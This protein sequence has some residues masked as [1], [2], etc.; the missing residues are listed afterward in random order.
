LFGAP[1]PAPAGGLFGAAPVAAAPVAPAPSAEALLAQQ[2]AAVENQKKQLELVQAWSGNPSPASKVVP[3][4]YYDNDL[5]DGWNGSGGSYATSSSALLS[6]RPAPRSAA[7][8]RPRGISSTKQSPIASLAR[9]NGSPILSPNRFVGSATKTLFIKP[10]SLTPKPKTRLMLTNGI[11]TN[12]NTPAATLENGRYGSP[13]VP[14]QE[15]ATSKAEESPK[16]G[17]SSMNGDKSPGLDLYKKVVGSPD[18]T[19]GS[20][21]PVSPVN[22]AKHLVPK[23]TKRGYEVFPSMADLEAMSEAELATVSGF[24]VERPGFGSVEWDGAVD[25]RCVDIDAE[26]VI[27]SKN[28]S[29]YDEAETT[30]KKPEQGSKLNRPAVITMYGIFPKDGAEAS[31]DAKEKLSR[32]IEKTTHKMKAELLSFES[33]SGVWKF[34]VGHFSRYGLDDSDDE[35]NDDVNAT[36]TLELSDDERPTWAED[37]ELGGA[38]NLRAPMDEDESTA[39]TDASDML[40]VSGEETLVHEIIREG[41]MAYAMMT[42]E[43]LEAPEHQAIIQYEESDDEQLLFPDEGVDAINTSTEE[44]LKPKVRPSRNSSS[45]GICSRLAAKSGITNESSSNIDYGMR[46]RRSFR[47]GWR[48]DG[49][50]VHLKPSGSGSHCLVQSKPAINNSAETNPATLPLL[51]THYKHKKAVGGTG[52][53]APIFTLPVSNKSLCDLLDDYSQSSSLC[54]LNDSTK[55]TVTNA[56]TLLTSLYGDD[57][58]DDKRRLQALTAWLK[59]VVSDDTM[60]DISA[61][62]SAGKTYAAIFAALAGGDTTLASSIALDTGN[63]RL[64]LLLANSGTQ[65]QPFYDQQLKMW[66]ESGAQALVDSDLLRIFSLASGSADVEKK[67][68]NTNATSYNIDWRRRFGM[69]L[70]SSPQGNTAKVSDA[71]EKYN[72]DILAKLAPAAKPLH[73]SAGDSQCVLYQILNHYI[74]NGTPI[75]SILSPISHTPYRHDFSASFH[76]GA[77]LS[78]LS[79]TNLSPGEEGLIV[80]AISSQLIAERSW[81]W[82]VYVTLCLLDRENASESMIVARQ[83]RAKAIV[84]R[85]YNPSNDSSAKNSREFLQSI[86]VPSTWFFESAAYRAQNNGHLFEMVENLKMVSLKDCL[87]GVESFLIPN[88]ILEGKEACGKLKAFLE[89]MSLMAS[90]EYS[91]YWNKPFGCGSILKF[92]VLAEKV[93]QLS[94]VSMDE[95]SMH[96]DEIDGLLQNVTDLESTLTNKANDENIHRLAA[97]VPYEISLAPAGV[98]Q[99]ELVSKVYLLRMQLVAIKNGQPLKGLT[100]QSSSQYDMSSGFFVAESILREL[101]STVSA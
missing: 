21:N 91:S 58:I 62:E 1:A 41:E 51:E 8:I 5:G 20:P 23:L 97:K 75:S 82:A 56:F 33:D 17:A 59:G 96:M 81:E 50:F 85:F 34:R 35:S 46:M 70:W 66:N 13:A 31:A 47:V 57:E 14:T 32:K 74:S 18:A 87:V 3:S 55:Q 77:T 37:K 22:T 29:V 80:D 44:P 64:S 94:N 65:S 48:P 25:V 63:Y 39:F 45:L 11:P 78:A 100:P 60:T 15:I 6:L 4:S 71:V 92:L 69:Y 12:G 49:S 79:T 86:G 19:G 98:V 73:S 84:S 2:L 99:A 67:M 54:Q 76:I 42:E 101:A 72:A 27:E 53:E 43:V 28:V 89:A 10:N 40:D 90:E 95:I 83:V 30:G 16:A 88:M 36:P 68:F 52:D 38:S 26:V 24:K 93:D 61:A 9:K 7:K